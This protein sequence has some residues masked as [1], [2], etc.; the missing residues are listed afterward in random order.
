[1]TPAKLFA[2]VSQNVRRN[3]KNFL[4]STFGIT[5]GVS[6][7]SFFLA[8]TMGIRDEVFNRNYPVELIEL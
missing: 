5:V 8:L 7:F 6:V 1:M 4:F 3:R 2:I